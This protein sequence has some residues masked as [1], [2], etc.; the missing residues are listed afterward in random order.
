LLSFRRKP[1][2]R[3][4]RT[5]WTPAFAGVTL[6][7]RFEIGSL[8]KDNLNH[9]SLHTKKAGKYWSVRIGK[10]YR[11]LATEVEGDLLWFWIGSHSE[12]D[13]LLRKK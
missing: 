1:E 6:F 4:F 2:S 10:R 5:F 7:N 13:E 12:Y 3:I 8:L 11:A 9:P